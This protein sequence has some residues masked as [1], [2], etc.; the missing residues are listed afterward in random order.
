MESV[1]Y[2]LEGIFLLH[3][4]VAE[5]KLHKVVFVLN[6]FEVGVHIFCH[7]LTLV[8]LNDYTTLVR[9][10]KGRLLWI[11]ENRDRRTVLIFSISRLDSDA[12]GVSGVRAERIPMLFRTIT[13]G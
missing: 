8:L 10:L 11:L 2:F 5:N 4:T 1:A 9:L 3:L 12:K 13:M 7:K 6:G